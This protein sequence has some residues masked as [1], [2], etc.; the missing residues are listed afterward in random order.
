MDGIEFTAALRKRE[1]EGMLKEL[2]VIICTGRSGD[3]FLKESYDN[4]VSEVLLKPIS[5][6]MLKETIENRGTSIKLL[7]FFYIYGCETLIH[8]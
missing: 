7:V 5:R 2:P 1:K 4:E 8:Y 6:H 3:V